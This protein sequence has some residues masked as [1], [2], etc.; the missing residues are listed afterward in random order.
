VPLCSCVDPDENPG[1]VALYARDS[2][3]YSDQYA[4]AERQAREFCDR[5]GMVEIM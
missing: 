1:P 3:A 5:C 2:D 4:A